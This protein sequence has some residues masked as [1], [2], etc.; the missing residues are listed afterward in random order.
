MP[1]IAIAVFSAVACFAA[2]ASLGGAQSNIGYVISVPKGSGA[3]G[4]VLWSSHLA[5]SQCGHAMLRNLNVREWC[6]EGTVPGVRP[7]LGR[8]KA[9]TVVEKLD[10]TECGDMVQVRVLSGELK[11]QVGCA[12]AAALTSAKPGP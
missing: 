8:L 11:D 1:R 7:K 12:A 9:G 4:Y 5:A 2:S 3:G 10:S 6:E